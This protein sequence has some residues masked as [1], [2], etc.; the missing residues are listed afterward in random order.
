MQSRWIMGSGA[1][2]D[3][4]FHAWSQARPDE[5]VHKLVVQQGEDY[6]FDLSCLDTLDPG[7]GP[8][9][10]AFDERFGNFKRME[11]MRA[12]LERGFRLEPFVSPLA[13][14]A[15]DV[16]LGTNAFLGP[17]VHIGH[18]SR[19]GF[20]SFVHA[21]AC[22]GP[23]TVLKASCWIESGVHIGAGAE[24]GAHSIVRQG[25]QVRAGVKVGRECELGWPQFYASD[26]PSKTF[27]DLRYDEPIHVYEA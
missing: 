1:C 7:A 14:V 22:L 27:Y 20:N 16:D 11:L 19:I 21:H 15:P 3:M 13:S 9:F 12:V 8:A 18:G 24:I 6:A 17:H 25:A 23:H 4:A 10:V 5:Q 26:V 2:L